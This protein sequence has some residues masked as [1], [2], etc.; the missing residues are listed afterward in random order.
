MMRPT[1]NAHLLENAEGLYPSTKL[2]EMSL[3]CLV[4]S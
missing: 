2:E 1:P 3:P 4:H